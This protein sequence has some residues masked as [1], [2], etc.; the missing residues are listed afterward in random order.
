MSYMKF[1][2]AVLL[3]ISMISFL[4][5]T[6]GST[7]NPAVT[8]T[9]DH[10]AAERV[11]HMEFDYSDIRIEDVSSEFGA[12]HSVYVD[13]LT[14]TNDPGRPMLAYDTRMV[15]VPAG[16]QIE[17]DVTH[18]PRT[19]YDDVNVVPC[20]VMDP[21][22]ELGFHFYK[23]QQVYT[24]RGMFPTQL[25]ELVDRGFIRGQEV[26]K[27]KVNPVQFDPVTKEVVFTDHIEVDLTFTDGQGYRYTEPGPFEQVIS[28]TIVNPD[29][30]DVIPRPASV[31]YQPMDG[32]PYLKV[33]VD[34]SGIYEITEEEVDAA[35][36][37]TT[38]IDPTTFRLMNAG[39]GMLDETPGAAIPAMQE[40]PIYVTGEGDSSFDSGDTITFFGQGAAYWDNDTWVENYYS[41]VNVYWL[42]WGGV[43]GDRMATIDLT[44]SGGTTPTSYRKVLHLEQDIEAT[45]ANMESHDHRDE[46]CWANIQ[47]ESAPWTNM[48]GLVKQ[49]G[50]DE[51]G[52]INISVNASRLRGSTAIAV[53]FRIQGV[54]EFY[55]MYIG[56]SSNTKV[57]LCKAT[58]QSTKQNL[59]NADFSVT[60]NQ[61]YWIN[62]TATGNRILCYIDDTLYIDHTDNSN[63]YLWGKVGFN[64][65]YVSCVQ[66]WDLK[67]NGSDTIG[68]PFVHNDDFSGYPLRSSG[69]P[70]WTD[71]QG[72][73][74]D[75]TV[76]D[77]AGT[78]VYRSTTMNLATTFEMGSWDT[79][80]D[81][82]VRPWVQGEEVYNEGDE[83]HTTGIYVND[84]SI[85]EQ[86]W[87]GYGLWL[88]NITIPNGDLREGTNEVELDMPGNGRD[89]L[90]SQTIDWI[91]VDYWKDFDANEDYF[92]FN[93]SAHAQGAGQHEFVVTNM[94]TSSIEGYK[95]Y[96]FNR[97]ERVINPTISADSTTYKYEFSD[98]IVNGTDRYVIVEEDAK[99][100][101][102]SLEKYVH[103]GLNTTT[104]DEDYLLITH[105]DL[106]NA[107]DASNPIVKLAAHRA[108]Q[109]GLNVSVI[110]T[111]QIYDE[112]SNGLTDPTAIRNFIS[113]AYSNWDGAPTY[114]LFA[115]D[116]SLAYRSTTDRASSLVPTYIYDDLGFYEKDLASDNWFCCVAGND[117][118]PDLIPGRLPFATLEEAEYTVDKIIFYET[119]PDTDGWRRNAVF[120]A[121]DK[122]QFWEGV[123]QETCE[124]HADNYLT[125]NGFNVTQEAYYEDESSSVCRSKIKQG[126]NDGAALVEYCGHGYP[127][128]WECFNS[129]DIR[130]LTNKDM[131]PFVMALACSNAQFDMPQANSMIEEFVVIEDKGAI[132]SWG[133]SRV[134]YASPIEKSFRF[135]MDDVFNNEMRD[136]GTRCYSSLIQGADAYHLKIMVYIGD[137]ALTYG[138]PEEDIN[139]TTNYV[140]YEKGETM[141]ISGQTLPGFSGNVNITLRDADMNFLDS[142]QKPFTNS[143]FSH[144]FTA[145]NI[146]GEVRVFAYVWDAGSNRD[147]LSWIDIEICDGGCNPR[148]REDMISVTPMPYLAGDELN[149]T[150]TVIN[151][152]TQDSPPIKVRFSYGSTLLSEVDCPALT[153]E[154]TWETTVHWNTT[155]SYGS[156]EVTVELD[157]DD[158]VSEL[159]ETD[160]LAVRMV[161]LF[162]MPIAQ[163][164]SDVVSDRLSDIAF[165]STGSHSPD[166]APLNYTWDLGDGNISYDPYPVHRY[167]GLGRYDVCLTVRDDRGLSD[168]AGMTV[169]VVNIE[170]SASFTIDANWGFIT[171]VFEFNSTSVDPDGG[172][173]SV[174]WDFGDGSNSTDGSPVHQY[175]SKGVF[176]IELTVFDADG[177]SSNCSSSVEVKNTGPIA[178]IEVSATS[179]GIG[180]AVSFSGWTSSDIDD[181]VLNYTWSFED[182]RARYGC[183]ISESFLSVGDETVNLMVTD[184]S[185]SY[186]MDT[187][188]ITVVGTGPVMDC[189][190]SAYTGTIFTVFTLD[191]T[192]SDADGFISHVMIDVGE[193]Y[194]T[195]DIFN[196][197]HT[198]ALTYQLTFD[199]IGVHTVRAYVVDNDGYS[200][201][202]DEMNI[203]I[204]NV[205][206]T[207]RLGSDV[208]VVVNQ[209]FTVSAVASDVD[210]SIVGYEWDLHGDRDFEEDTSV[211]Y[212]SAMYD[213]EGIY[214]FTVRVKDDLGGVAEASIN[215][216]VTK[217]PVDIE[218]V[219][220]TDGGGGDGGSG[221]ATDGQDGGEDG[222][223]DAGAVGFFVIA[224]LLLVLLV[225]ATVVVLV[226]RGKK[227]A[228]PEDIATEEGPEENTV[229]DEEPE[230]VPEESPEDL[231]SE[232]IE[233]EDPL[234]QPEEGQEDLEM[235]DEDDF[236][237]DDLDDLDLDDLGT[238]DEVVK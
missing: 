59:K 146:V 109:S 186:S 203:T 145:P 53:M 110:N 56:D 135:F 48:A 19:S 105:R 65:G 86:D 171:K 125:P 52:N 151:W 130:G 44:P 15:G 70:A 88:P 66:F 63:P 27:V 144:Q 217:A 13:D 93:H 119:T 168:V 103:A 67:I 120:H 98:T 24:T 39:G 156:I 198:E 157:P 214:T 220:G 20:P 11:C 94:S 188:T 75:F 7:S 154:E 91:E 41:N 205:L 64:V 104:N 229:E 204:E 4:P 155:G 209:T 179:V 232:S 68:T 190:L 37:D 3:A 223:V 12:Y 72:T 46:A 199:T 83:W 162:R 181:D 218:Y 183:N 185:G 69:Y 236:N 33:S 216:T 233:E 177:G 90:D 82:V 89:G 87:K 165:S 187:V 184:P 8:I 206:P 79:L 54:N 211:P 61:D 147:G 62:I 92:D 191:I 16:A 134:A 85:V 117:L 113:Y 193:G 224:A 189:S 49:T 76:R 176:L 192:A 34:H 231:Y 140:L 123:F 182:G 196:S 207:V 138:L 238:D 100:K 164:G 122:V 128:S 178:N 228:E 197:E 152:G 139:I 111:Q 141:T 43:A 80:E 73:I 9:D 84:N 17:F 133:A 200:S 58:P 159:H 26:V 142:V 14:L 35:G 137:P 36:I 118:Y 121:D 126:I 222:G 124:D 31:G 2:L 215:I 195:K 51:W 132:A 99:M 237:M 102:V 25:V 174:L 18:G 148:I 149:I 81:V 158:L 55:V 173:V 6:I 30:V 42:T 38:S 1:M 143:A 127:F 230:E 153:R 167:S 78:F 212:V 108:T 234:E 60:T 150:A 221:N 170:P 47:C 116:S 219:N 166:G 210:G 74:G 101:P 131:Y 227:T 10:E 77:D 202:I 163:A 96:G 32:P 28:S 213:T 45:H 22:T 114:V 172:I 175:T 57:T 50:S 194:V 169:D 23:D 136:L 160:N 29:V 95:V 201:D 129:G 71:L 107:S 40:V 112:F 208:S 226:L 5:T 161:S 225:V 180:Q 115:G 235:D 21:S 106:Y 97:T